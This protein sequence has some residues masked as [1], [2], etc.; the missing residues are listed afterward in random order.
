MSN[1]NLDNYET[2]KERK[3]RFYSDYKDGRI[4]VEMVNDDLMEKAVFMA[5]IYLTG[6][7]QEKGL[8]RSTGYA[9]EVRDKELKISNYGKEYESVNYSSWTENCEESAVGRALDNAGY[10][11]SPSREEMAKA[12]GMSK[13]MKKVNK[14]GIDTS[15][16]PEKPKEVKHCDYHNADMEWR[17]S[18]KKGKWYSYHMK[19]N[20]FCFGTGTKSERDKHKKKVYSK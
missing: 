17:W 16:R 11:S 18:D 5:T 8:A 9:L 15:N 14:D 12:E 6:K 20:E 7:D 4:I 10:A 1:F 13:T 19:D 3:K 2:V